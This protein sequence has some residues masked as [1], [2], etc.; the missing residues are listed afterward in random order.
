MKMEHEFDV[1]IIGGG[2]TGS[3][4]AYQFMQA[5]FTCCLVER[6]QVSRGSTA[7]ST[8]LL[9]YELDKS[10]VE[11]SRT[12]GEDG[13]AF[14]YTE[15]LKSLHQIRHLSYELGNTFAF[16]WLDS[17]YLA[18]NQSDANELH[19][20]NELKKRLG[21]LSEFLDSERLKREY[22]IVANG[23]LKSQEAA[24]IDPVA[25]TNS[26]MQHLTAIGLMVFENE[27]A[28]IH[29]EASFNRVSTPMRDIKST[30]L[31][32]ASGYKAMDYID[33]KAVPL[34]INRTF[35]V[36]GHSQYLENLEHE[37]LLWET[38][39]PYFY[40]R[41]TSRGQYILGG[42][43][44][45]LNHAPRS[46]ALLQQ[47]ENEILVRFHK[48]FPEAD[49]QVASVLDAVFVESADS[50]PVLYKVEQFKNC[51][52]VMGSGGNGILFST[53]AARALIEHMQGKNSQSFN[54]LKP[55]RLYQ[56]THSYREANALG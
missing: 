48:Y 32:I 49:F 35:V 8:A 17:L 11:M 44:V 9:Q 37:T 43:D 30:L 46:P 31:V 19:A 41:S 15:T 1:C 24:Q 21:F 14:A 34:E 39:R 12:F 47:K 5:G 56:N 7:Q 25:L 42:G 2:I 27:E 40:M 4:I 38:L 28:E 20:E 10:L 26:L 36:N 18:P 16:K 13:A 22:N 6:G 53:W 52:T 51:Y 45:P 3:L 50:L 23:A 55:E 54:L 33:R 29:K